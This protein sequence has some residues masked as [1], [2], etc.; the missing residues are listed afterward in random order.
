MDSTLSTEIKM[1]AFIKTQE[2]IL[3]ISPLEH[4][5]A[6]SLF[7]RTVIYSGTCDFGLSFTMDRE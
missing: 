1:H 6:S 4:V 2:N 7:T 3:Q 5:F